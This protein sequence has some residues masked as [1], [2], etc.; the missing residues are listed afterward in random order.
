MAALP[1]I[2]A[3]GAAGE[4]VTSAAGAGGDTFTITGAERFFV[5]NGNASPCVVTMTAQSPNNDGE[6]VDYEYTVPAGQV[7]LSPILNKRRLADADGIAHV[8]YSVT[9]TISV[10][11]IGGCA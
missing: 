8:S 1:T 6:L 9:A 5:D 2:L 10:A 4:I 3:S 11:V 7:W